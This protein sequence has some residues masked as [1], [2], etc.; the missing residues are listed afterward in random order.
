MKLEFI[1]ESESEL[2]EIV[3]Y[4][5]DIESGLGLRF[6]GEVLTTLEWLCENAEKPRL[7]SSG[8]RRINLKVFPYYIAY[9]IRNRIVYIVAIAHTH[10]KPEFWKM[11]KI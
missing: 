7:R 6:K 10:R 2:T 1:P 3:E 9:V 4:Y 8:Y 5:E 11:R